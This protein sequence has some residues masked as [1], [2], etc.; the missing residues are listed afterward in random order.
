MGKATLAFA[1][2]V[3]RPEVTLAQ[4]KSETAGR[5]YF[6]TYPAQWQLGYS[7]VPL[8]QYATYQYKTVLGGMEMYLVAYQ[9][10][11]HFNTAKAYKQRTLFNL[12]RREFFSEVVGVVYRPV[13]GSMVP[14]VV[15]MMLLIIA[16]IWAIIGIDTVRH[17]T[18]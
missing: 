13:L 2:G 7:P 10:V 12:E 14:L 16:F 8:H 18:A 15:G 3:P 5:P 4:F 6:L 1:P 9:W 11:P 17:R